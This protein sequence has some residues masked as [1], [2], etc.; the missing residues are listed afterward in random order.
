MHHQWLERMISD[1]T[2][3]GDQTTGQKITLLQRHILPMLS[4][5]E[6]LDCA[7]THNNRRKAVS[8]YTA[9]GVVLSAQLL[10]TPLPTASRVHVI[11]SVSA[12]PMNHY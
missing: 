11:R 12:A 2:V 10:A 8:R 6:R 4:G 3:G 7:S 1:S 9:P 5:R